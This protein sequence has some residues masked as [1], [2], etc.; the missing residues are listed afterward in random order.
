MLTALFNSIPYIKNPSQ[1][2]MSL[3]INCPRSFQSLPSGQE[4]TTVPSSQEGP[5]PWCHPSVPT[6]ATLHAQAE[7]LHPRFLGLGSLHLPPT[8][9]LPTLQSSVLPTLASC[10]PNTSPTHSF[11]ILFPHLSHS[12]EG[13]SRSNHARRETLGDGWT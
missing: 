8:T 2:G 5:L 3:K 13:G 4:T 6:P 7:P 12:E 1:K 9:F 11:I 10:L